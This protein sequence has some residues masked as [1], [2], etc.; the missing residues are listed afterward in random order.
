MARVTDGLLD[1]GARWHAAVEAQR[2]LA[3]RA[4][5]TLDFGPHQTQIKQRTHILAGRA[6]ECS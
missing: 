1:S 6:S 4:L 3:A 5:S 2:Q